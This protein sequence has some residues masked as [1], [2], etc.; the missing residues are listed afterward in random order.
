MKLGR[1]F[2]SQVS[3]STKAGT[4]FYWVS[5][6]LDVFTNCCVDC[7]KEETNAAVMKKYIII[8][9]IVPSSKI[10]YLQER[11]FRENT[12]EFS[13]LGIPIPIVVT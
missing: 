8:I 4:I 13:T 3:V 6:P 5:I 7:T 12:G 10:G 1:L 11:P 9:I 2:Y